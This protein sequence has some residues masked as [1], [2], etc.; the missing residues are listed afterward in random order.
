MPRPRGKR[1]GELPG[2]FR[3]SSARGRWRCRRGC[4]PCGGP[5]PGPRWTC[6]CAWC[7]AVWWKTIAAGG[8][9]L[10]HAA[11]HEMRRVVFAVPFISITQQ[12][13]AVYRSLLDP[14]EEDA[15]SEPVV[16]EHHSSVGLYEDS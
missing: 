2:W 8:F 13:A 15:D 10:R 14:L 7:S 1:L 11:R 6:W 4:R 9:A 5:Q 16:L 3:R 12:N